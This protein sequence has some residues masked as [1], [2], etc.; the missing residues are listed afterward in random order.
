MDNS[1]IG[2]FDFNGN[3][4]FDFTEIIPLKYQKEFIHCEFLMDHL[5]LVSKDN[6]I[7]YF[8]SGTL[9]FEN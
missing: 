5:V 6:N 2:I 9:K 4:L 7:I 8:N 3:F 1:K